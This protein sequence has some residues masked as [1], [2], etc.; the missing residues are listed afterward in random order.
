[1][2]LELKI[3]FF[4]LTETECF[5]Q[6][7]MIVELKRC[8]FVLTKKK[9]RFFCTDCFFPLRSSHSGS[10]DCTWVTFTSGKKGRILGNSPSWEISFR[11]LFVLKAHVD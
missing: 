1:M 2:I 8:F 11:V 4:A 5:N 3:R 7:V 9:P 6:I 10:L